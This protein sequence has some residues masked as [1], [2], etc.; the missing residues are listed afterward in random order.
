MFTLGGKRFLLVHATPRDPMD[1]YAPPDVSFWAP[2]IANLHVD[3]LV[4]GHTHLPY[5][6]QV[7]GTMVINPGSVGLSRDGNPRAAYAVID[8]N[9]VELKRVEYPIEETIAAVDAL[10][11]DQTARQMLADIYRSGTYL[12]KWIRENGYSNGISSSNGDHGL[13]LAS[14]T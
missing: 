12:K 6:L 8:N 2:R 4:A 5:T 1:E 7:N 13:K 3:Y 11:P 14:G 10:V 9:E